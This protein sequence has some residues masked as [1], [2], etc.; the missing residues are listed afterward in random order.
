MK[1]QHRLEK[2]SP[3]IKRVPWVGKMKSKAKQNHAAVA[4]LRLA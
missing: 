3:L 1:A 4:K 2:K